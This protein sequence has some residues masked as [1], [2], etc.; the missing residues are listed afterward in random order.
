MSE[1]RRRF[2]IGVIDKEGAEK[3]LLIYDSFLDDKAS[4]SINLFNLGAGKYV[5]YERSS[6]KEKLRVATESE[7]KDAFPSIEGYSMMLDIMCESD[8]IPRLPLE[9]RRLWIGVIEWAQGKKDFLIYDSFKKWHNET[10]VEL[11]SVNTGGCIS[12]DRANI[13][14]KVRKI[15]ERE[16]SEAS[17]FLDLYKR[18]SQDFRDKRIDVRSGGYA[19]LFDDYYVCEKYIESISEVGSRNQGHMRAMLELSID[20]RLLVM[21]FL[22]GIVGDGHWSNNSD[23]DTKIGRCD[24]SGED[25]VV[26]YQLRWH[27]NYDGFNED[28]DEYDYQDSRV[29]SIVD[30]AYDSDGACILINGHENNGYYRSVEYDPSDEPDE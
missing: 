25:S 28:G 15:C 27:Y 12:F 18:S 1:E 9:Y 10:H 11:F 20:D 6:V 14:R 7:A 4:V 13:R 30:L 22:M 17:G 5:S 21:D 24:V 8:V 19:T 3:E 26:V 16:A 23:S 29:V 2:W